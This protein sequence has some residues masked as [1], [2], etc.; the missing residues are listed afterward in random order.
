MKFYLKIIL[1][2]LI[3]YFGGPHFG[4]WWIAVSAF[5]GG[6][7]IKTSGVRSF[8]SGAF[9]VGIVWLWM[10][11]KIDIETGSILTQKIAVLFK[12]GHQ[13]FIIGLTVLL[14]SMVGALSAWTGHN[15]RKLFDRPRRGYYR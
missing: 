11:L 6:G 15:F 13:G 8:F 9:G 12:V 7:L 5:I 2:A 4:W 10:S 3:L 1:I 14:G